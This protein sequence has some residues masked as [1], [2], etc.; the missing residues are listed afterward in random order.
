[1]TLR[2]EVA[3]SQCVVAV[4]AEVEVVVVLVLLSLGGLTRGSRRA[5][6]RRWLYIGSSVYQMLVSFAV[7]YRCGVANS[8]VPL[9]CCIFFVPDEFVDTVLPSF[10][11]SS[12]SSW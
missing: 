8:V 5:C 6:L 4:V 11:Q 3:G 1:M 10:Y 9:S 2:R 7:F 12:L